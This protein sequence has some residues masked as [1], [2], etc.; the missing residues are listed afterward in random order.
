MDRSAMEDISERLASLDGLYFPGA[1]QRAVPDPAQRKSALL[2]LLSRDAPIFLERY[3]AELTSDELREFDKLRKDYEV[4]WHLNLLNRRRNPT[5]EDDRARSVTVKNRRRAYMERLVQDG[6]Y[7]SEDAMREREP[8]LHHEYLGKFQDPAGRSL[9]RPGERW[10]DTLMRRCEEAMIVEKIRGEQQRL[11]VDMREW[12]G[13][14]AEEVEVYEEEEEDDEEQDDDG[15]DDDDDDDDTVKLEHRFGEIQEEKSKP[16]SKKEK[17]SYSDM[18]VEED[19]VPEGNDGK[20]ISVSPKM[21]EQDAAAANDTCLASAVRPF[22]QILSA[23]EMQDQL[24]QFTHIMQQKFLAG[25][26]TTYLDYSLI[27][28]DERLDDHWIKE[29]NY[30]AEEKYFEE[31]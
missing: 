23:E 25:E 18:V 7:F 17:E 11:G 8:Y 15:D 28:N 1:M 21:D 14:G 29:A 3:G 2:D 26:D 10:S 5:A 6:E 31:D 4:G 24:E 16:I 12:V 27:D 9:S 22:E 30:D 20:S 13:G 19:K